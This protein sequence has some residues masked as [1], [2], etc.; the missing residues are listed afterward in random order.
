M[1]YY[2]W[3][4][5]RTATNLLDLSDAPLALLGLVFGEANDGLVSAC[6]SRL[7]KSLG[8]YSQNHLDEVNQL[9]GLRDWFSTD[10]VTL[11]REHATRLKGLGL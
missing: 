2:S 9:L 8:D 6:S 11:Y 10:P 4:G 1:R 5:T 3:T 7:G